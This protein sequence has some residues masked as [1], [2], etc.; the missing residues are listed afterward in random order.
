MSE[1]NN[2]P[3]IIGIVAAAIIALI[4]GLNSGNKAEPEPNSEPQE[5]DFLKKGLVAYYPFNGNANDESG[6]GHNGVLNGVTATEDRNGKMDKA[7][8]LDGKSYITTPDSESLRP[9]HI[10][11]TAWV[12]TD[13]LGMIVSKTKNDAWGEQYYL[14]YGHFGEPKINFSIKRNSGGNPGSGWQR[15]LSDDSVENRISG[16]G[17]VMLC[18]SWDG[19]KQ[20]VYLNGNKVGQ[21]ENAP[22]GGI[23]DVEGGKLFIGRMWDGDP[24]YFRGS[25]DDIRIYK[26]ALTEEQVKALYEWEKPKAE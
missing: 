6:N 14:H 24:S 10:T 8:F 21:N 19:E 9:Q 23:D 17:W 13:G 1:K 16:Q 4:I 26:R 3:A 7:F 15:G 12:K 11:I 2:T 20:K 25:L 5:P 18:A 22:A